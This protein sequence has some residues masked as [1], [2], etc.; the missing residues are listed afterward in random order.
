[1]LVALAI[2]RSEEGKEIKWLLDAVC[3]LDRKLFGN[4]P[5]ALPMEAAFGEM[6]AMV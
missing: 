3:A 6:Q 1:M 5:R 2:K 4:L